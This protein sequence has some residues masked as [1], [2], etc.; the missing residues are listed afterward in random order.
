MG[1][2][3]VGEWHLKPQGG[4]KEAPFEVWDGLEPGTGETPDDRVF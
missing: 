3:F 4:E 1:D 2:W